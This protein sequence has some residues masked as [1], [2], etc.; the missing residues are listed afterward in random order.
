MLRWPLVW[1]AVGGAVGGAEPVRVEVSRDAW[2]SAY[3]SER[4]GNN[5][6]APKLKLKG[7]QE[8][9]LIDFD[10]AALRGKRV[11]RA[12]L[13]LRATGQESLGRTTVSSVAE[14]WERLRPH[15]RGEQLRVGRH[16]PPALA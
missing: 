6:G 13:H 2:I 9:F 7:I 5:G 14:P 4:E 16:R 3:P 11:T 12:S 1:L 10:P 15:A 8:F